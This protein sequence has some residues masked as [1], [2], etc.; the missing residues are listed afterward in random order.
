M[1]D[2]TLD[3]I[4]HVI[5][6]GT[7]LGM[8]Q[9]IGLSGLYRQFYEIKEKGTILRDRNKFPLRLHARRVQCTLLHTTMLILPVRLHTVITQKYYIQVSTIKTS[10]FTCCT[11]ICGNFWVFLNQIRNYFAFYFSYKWAKDIL[12]DLLQE[13]CSQ[14]SRIQAGNA[15]QQPAWDN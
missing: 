5:I 7:I 15:L 10:N 1:N 6:W 4:G 12:K 11:T 14:L 3:G 9:N 8:Q 13:V 2:G